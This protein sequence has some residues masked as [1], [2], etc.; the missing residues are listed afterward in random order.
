V[1]G[2]VRVEAAD[3]RLVFQAGLVSFDGYRDPDAWRRVLRWQARQ[4]RYEATGAWLRLEGRPGPAR[5]EEAFE[6]VWG[7]RR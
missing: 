6:R 3:N 5:D 2:P 1:A 4:N 7:D